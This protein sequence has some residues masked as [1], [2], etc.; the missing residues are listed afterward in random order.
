MQCQVQHPVKV[1]SDNLG[2]PKGAPGIQLAMGRPHKKGSSSEP[3]KFRC[4]VC[5]RLYRMDWAIQ[6]HEKVCPWKL[7]A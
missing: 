2:A 6:N 7:L 1:T 5:G 3:K 4:S